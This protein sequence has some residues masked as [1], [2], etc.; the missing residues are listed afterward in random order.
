MKKPLTFIKF[1]LFFSTS[2][3]AF[4]YSMEELKS[5][6][7]ENNPELNKLNQEYK[8]SQLDVKDAYAGLGPTVDMQ[9]SGTYMLNPPVD[10]IYINVDEIMDSIQW[11]TG[12]K[13][14][15]SGQH[16]KIYDG[17]ENTLYNFQLSLTQPIF[18]WGKLENA[19]KLYKQI[20]EIKQTQILSVQ[21]QME[22]E[23]ETR[24]L[25]LYYL[26][27]ILQ[28]LEEEKEYAKRMV[29]TSE[30]AEK[31]GMLLHQD[32]VDARIQAKELDIAQQDVTEQINNQLLELERKTGIE[33]LNLDS[34]EYDFDE[35]VITEIM[36]LDRNLVQENALSGNQLSIKMLTQLQ[37]VQETAEKIAKGYVNWKPDIALQATAGYSGSRAPFIEP[38]WRRKD[39]YSANIS[40]G[41]R[42]TI[43]DG[44]KKLHDVSRKIT[45]TK[46]ADI[47]KLDARSTI[48]QTLN[49]QWNTADVCT[50]KIEYQE[51]KIESANAKIE[52][53]QLMYNSGYGSET[54]LLT[55]KIE[56]CNQQIEKEKQN[57]S[58]AVA[59]LT[60][61]FLNK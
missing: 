22:T 46:I 3:S 48:K 42:T 33:N 7:L 23:L 60:I 19:V 57:L 1:L 8:Q 54:D 32:V 17:M 20:A 41:I 26:N 27:N 45:E 51:L 13:P 56:K 59:C 2:F 11:P 47:N 25:S 39:D 37:Q 58:R 50:M 6:M 28:I 14:A 35:S 49:S 53:Q 40:I 9:I 21:Q 16:I 12:I 24:L 34:I 61:R 4:S 31:S 55:A 52:H 10:A 18:T 30:N 43:W 15:G 36:N 5:A 38:N 29:E 44:G